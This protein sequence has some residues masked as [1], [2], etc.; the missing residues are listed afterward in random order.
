MKLFFED[1]FFELPQF[2][3]K[4]VIVGDHLQEGPLETGLSYLDGVGFLE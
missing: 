2:I 3:L 1:E 4:I